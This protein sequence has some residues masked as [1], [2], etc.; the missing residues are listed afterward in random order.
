[1][2]DDEKVVRIKVKA[3]WVGGLWFTAWLFTIGCCKLSFWSGV[4]ALVVW[5]YYIG[6]RF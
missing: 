5:Q 3:E 2:S 1:M 6:A 4:W